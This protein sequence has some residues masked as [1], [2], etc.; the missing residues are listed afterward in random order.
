[1]PKPIASSPKLD[2]SPPTTPDLG[3]L[4]SRY[5]QKIIEA[6][7]FIASGHELKAALLLREVIRLMEDHAAGQDELK[8]VLR[9][10]ADAWR[11]AASRFTAQSGE[12]LPN[13]RQRMRVEFLAEARAV[14]MA[15]RDI[16]NVVRMTR[17]TADAFMARGQVMGAAKLA[18][19]AFS[20]A[21]RYTALDF[22]EVQQFLKQ[23]AEIYKAAFEKSTTGRFPDNLDLGPKAAAFMYMTATTGEA[24]NYLQV[25]AERYH[26]VAKIYHGRGRHV[27]A[28]NILAQAIV[29]DIALGRQGA[30]EQHADQIAQYAILSGD[31]KTLIIYDRAMRLAQ[32]G[33]ALAATTMIQERAQVLVAAKSRNFYALKMFHEALD[34]GMNYVTQLSMNP[35]YDV[36]LSDT[37]ILRAMWL[38]MD[39]TFRQT[40]AWAQTLEM[41]EPLRVFSAIREFGKGGMEGLRYGNTMYVASLTTAGAYEPPSAHHVRADPYLLR[42]MSGISMTG[43]GASG[44]REIHVF[45]ANQAGCTPAEVAAAFTPYGDARIVS[46]LKAMT[47]EL[48]FAQLR[49]AALTYAYVPLNK[50]W[51]RKK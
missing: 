24:S 48:M 19:E 50:Q 15:L 20:L 33:S 43:E 8:P 16:P 29:L 34:A 22:T 11:R 25:V 27:E 38:Q 35:F 21:L 40:M 3:W 47:G 46:R 28:F 51:R 26:E 9:L 6:T 32:I 23:M 12:L 42:L 36:V 2:P 5:A 14:Y 41:L 13:V 44:M 17:A 18:G 7:A 4:N 1:M 37:K 49:H 45:L 31:R 10:Y 30:I 39:V